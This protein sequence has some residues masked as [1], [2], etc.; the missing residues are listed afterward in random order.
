MKVIE[1]DKPLCILDVETTGLDISKDNII[2]IGILKIMPDKTT[3]Y[4]S[5]NIRPKIPMHPQASEVLGIKDEDLTDYLYFE[6]YAQ[7]IANK[8]EGCDIAGFNSDR[9]DIPII[10]EEL[11]RAGIKFDFTGMRTIDVMKIYHEH[12]K[13]NL[14]A[15]YQMYCGK[16][17]KD[18][19][20]VKADVIATASILS[21]QVNAHDIGNTSA[22][23]TKWT[24]R[25]PSQADYG[26]KLK[27]NEDKVLCFNFGKYKDTPVKEVYQKDLG[28]LKWISDGDFPLDTKK[29]IVVGLT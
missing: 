1:L 7:S 10:V 27:Y 24:Y 25:D 11:L 17:L 23:L 5:A 28:Y 19:H 26:G 6:H 16:E 15:A 18:A 14:Q 4:F 2:E 12:N 9:F 21:A 13:R 3:S 29:M 22:E 20:T 8:L